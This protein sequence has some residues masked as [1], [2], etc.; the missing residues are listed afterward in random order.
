MVA[1]GFFQ[2][3][4]SDLFELHQFRVDLDRVRLPLHLGPGLALVRRGQVYLRLRLVDGGEPGPLGAVE[5]ADE[6]PVRDEAE[7]G[8]EVRRDPEPVSAS[9]IVLAWSSSR[10]AAKRR[11]YSVLAALPSSFSAFTRAAATASRRISVLGSLSIFGRSRSGVFGSM[12]ASSSY[13]IRRAGGACLR[14]S[15]E[16][17]ELIGGELL[18]GGLLLLGDRIHRRSQPVGHGRGRVVHAGERGEQA[19]GAEGDE[20]LPG[21]PGLLVTGPFLGHGLDSI[22]V[23]LG[24]GAVGGRRRARGCE[25]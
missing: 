18:A 14:S 22:D 9:A 13:A 11:V 4:D 1:E 8:L 25:Q 16:R 7:L 10:T 20:V 3:H 5:R 15:D 19:V 12:S 24:V 6:H 17:F 21:G 2:V 23:L